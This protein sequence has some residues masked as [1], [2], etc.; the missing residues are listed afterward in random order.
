[1]SYVRGKKSCSTTKY[2]S[3]SYL[4]I[5]QYSIFVLWNINN[6]ILKK[7]YRITCGLYFLYRE[8]LLPYCSKLLDHSLLEL[9]NLINFSSQLYPHSGRMFQDLNIIGKI[10]ASENF[11]DILNLPSSTPCNNPL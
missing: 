3:F 10:N 11:S 6:T 2:P 5:L 7:L 8:L 9:D 1:M 4:S